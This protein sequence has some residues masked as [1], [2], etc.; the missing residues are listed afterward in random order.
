MNWKNIGENER[1]GRNALIV[2]GFA[3]NIVIGQVG[4]KF[5]VF[6]VEGGENVPVPRAGCCAFESDAGGQAAPGNPPMFRRRASSRW[7][8]LGSSGSKCEVVIL[9]AAK[10]LRC[11]QGRRDSSLRSRMTDSPGRPDCDVLYLE[12]EEPKNNESRGSGRILERKQDPRS[13]GRWIRPPT[14][15]VIRYAI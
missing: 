13:T 12:P 11:P 8:E 10:D 15:V 3:T 5:S 7:Q 6:S 4:V 14:E 2:S 1:G 9:S